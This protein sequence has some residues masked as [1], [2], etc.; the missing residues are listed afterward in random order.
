MKY[1]YVADWR[2]VL[3]VMAKDYFKYNILDNF[4]IRVREANSTVYPS[5]QTGYEQYYTD[6]E[7]CWRQ[8]YNNELKSQIDTTKAKI[9]SAEKSVK[10][11]EK[12]VAKKEKEL[13]AASKSLTA[14]TAKDEPNQTE[15]DEANVKVMTVSNELNALRVE[16][17]KSIYTLD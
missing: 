6:I 2:E 16:L 4:E 13:T 17:D 3:H 10:S 11:N 8:L 1:K 12:A 14:A 7:V 5:G 9:K 15:I